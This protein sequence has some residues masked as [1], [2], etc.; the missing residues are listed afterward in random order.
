MRSVKIHAFAEGE[1]LARRIGELLDIPTVTAS[2]HRFPDGETLVRAALPADREAVIVRSLHDPNAK[3]IEVLLLGD[4][5]RRAGTKRITLVCAYLPYM[6]QDN[7]FHRGEALSQRV[8][9]GLLG[10]HFDRII[11]LE[12]HLH[13]TRDLAKVFGCPAQSVSAAP[14][15]AEWLGAR[16]HMEFVVV[17]PDREATRLVKEVATLSGLTATVGTKHRLADRRVEIKLDGSSKAKGAIVVYD[18]ASSGVTLAAVVRS[19]GDRN[20]APIEVV[21]AHALFERGAVSLIRSAGARQIVSC[22]SIAHTTNRIDIA[23]LLAEAVG[24]VTL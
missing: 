21:V 23:P 2:V 24:G 11:T 16:K 18:I 9:G 5:L 19:L 14:A 13:R 7:V 10:E 8:I 22:N 15:I 4:A 3:L 20:I 1:A 6:R 12:A 17:G